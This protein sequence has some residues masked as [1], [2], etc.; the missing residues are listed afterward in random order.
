MQKANEILYSCRSCFP[1][2][3][4]PPVGM[5]PGLCPSDSPSWEWACPPWIVVAEASGASIPK[6]NVIVSIVGLLRLP[7]TSPSRDCFLT[8]SW[9]FEPIF[10]QFFEPIPSAGPY[11][12]QSKYLNWHQYQADRLTF[13]L[14]VGKGT[15]M[16]PRVLEVIE[17][18]SLDTVTW[19][20]I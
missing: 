3:L 16:K 11:C 19:R 7:G 9:F 20:R 6:W 2:I 10:S 15:H 13:L 14:S 5:R 1:G 12:L 17:K 18:S 4:W 8:L